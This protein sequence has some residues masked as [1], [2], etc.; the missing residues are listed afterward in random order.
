MSSSSASQPSSSHLTPPRTPPHS[1][2]GRTHSRYYPATLSRGSEADGSVSSTSRV[3]LHRRG[4]SRTYE[5]LEDLLR[6]AGYKETRIVT[7]KS[8]RR[9]SR[10]G[11]NEDENGAAVESEPEAN[12]NKPTGVM[13]FLSGL[14]QRKASN[15]DPPTD[16]SLTVNNAGSSSM[17]A[18][19]LSRARTIETERASSPF[20]SD[21]SSISSFRPRGRKNAGRKEQQQA[22]TFGDRPVH[23]H[24][25]PERNTLR[26]QPSLPTY[27]QASPARAY[28]RHMASA[29][30]IPRSSISEHSDSRPQRSVVDV[31]SES[32][33]QPPLPTT[34][35]ETVARA[36]LNV[37]GSHAGKPGG[38][39]ESASSRGRLSSSTSGES[40]IRP[41]RSYSSGISM[42][43]GRTE[44]IVGSRGRTQTP[45]SSRFAISHG[46]LLIPSAT[47]ATVDIVPVRVVC[48]S[49]PASR[50]SSRVRGGQSPA[51][52]GSVRGKGKKK[53]QQTKTRAKSD[54]RKQSQQ[55]QQ[56][57]QQ[58]Q[59]RKGELP[60]LTVR[61]EGEDHAWA[62]DEDGG[63]S[64][65][66]EEGEVDLTKLL[67]SPKRQMSIQSLRK[68]LDTSLPRA[69]P[70]IF[71]GGD[72]G[73]EGE[74][75][76]REGSM[77]KATNR[78]S[79]RALPRVWD[80]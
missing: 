1:Y 77:G 20:Q 74:S 49:A 35:Y 51:D 65:E 37:P 63:E 31:S 16:S 19:P 69:L 22:P 29:P 17:P 52:L 38:Q 66:E 18:S 62:T 58:R 75:T 73:E 55:R 25:P 36:L 9:Y 60:S 76:S 14:V 39:V 3:P 8:N 41:A 64:S 72:G 28:L 27:A 4:K 50:V 48:R 33:R 56:Q 45:S 71:V 70:S 47:P 67:V 7:P 43:R 57:S 40:T 61:V 32:E 68:H 15:I 5:A 11:N 46:G 30:T 54:T 79:R 23:L 80:D 26:S 6:E 44:P 42:R 34:W 2:R 78:R 24:L 21:V 12:A 10:G 13:R 53:R 59:R